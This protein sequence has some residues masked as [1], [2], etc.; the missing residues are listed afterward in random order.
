MDGNR[1][2][3]AADQLMLMAT[4]FSGDGKAIR[5]MLKKLQQD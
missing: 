2:R 4:A 1:R 5:E 3:E